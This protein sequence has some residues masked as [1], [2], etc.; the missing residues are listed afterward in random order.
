M[1]VSLGTFEPEF[2]A[3]LDSETGPGQESKAAHEIMG[4]ALSAA[5]MR[6][7]CERNQ[8]RRPRHFPLSVS[9]SLSPYMYDVPSYVC[10]YVC[11]YVCMRQT[12]KLMLMLSL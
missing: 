9:L 6:R 7:F 4:K 12:S 1:Q 5:F 2:P 8:M 10:T 3:P 11:M